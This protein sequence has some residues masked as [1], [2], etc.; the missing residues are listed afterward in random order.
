MTS[1][2]EEKSR[3]FWQAAY[4][5]K[6]PK[7]AKLALDP[8]VDLNSMGDVNNTPFYMACMRG[9]VD[10]VRFMLCFHDN[11][12]AIDYNLVEPGVLPPFALACLLG[13]EKVI[14]AM[15]KDKRIDVIKCGQEGKSPLWYAAF[16][17]HMG[18]VKLL[19]ASGRE[20][21][22]S[23]R[24]GHLRKTPAEV[25]KWQGMNQAAAVIQAYE[26]DPQK[27]R[28]LLGMELGYSGMLRRVP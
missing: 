27:V 6:L 4:R 26:K 25:A 16:H 12:R 3:K 17:G 2:S 15:V 22:T 19:L 20:I 8:K 5:N 21:E 13:H 9:H 18:I 11:Q 24:D 1:F 23:R 10:I 14:E 28:F 7:L